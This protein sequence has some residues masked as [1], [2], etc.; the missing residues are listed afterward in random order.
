MIFET[1]QRKGGINLSQKNLAALLG[2]GHGFRKA[3]SKAQRLRWHGSWKTIMHNFFN[4]QVFPWE[5]VV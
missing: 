5:V 4:H 3:I 2:F 1:M